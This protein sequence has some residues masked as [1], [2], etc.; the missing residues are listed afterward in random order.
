MCA[1]I[2]EQETHRECRVIGCAS[3]DQS[4]HGVYFVQQLSVHQRGVPNLCKNISLLLEQCASRN[5]ESKQQNAFLHTQHST[6]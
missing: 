3:I 4:A 1:F 2:L 6:V 5:Y